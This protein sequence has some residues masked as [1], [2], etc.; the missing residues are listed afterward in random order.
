MTSAAEREYAA[1]AVARVREVLDGELAV[2][3][4]E[5]IARISERYFLGER[6]NVDPHHVTTA[7]RVLASSG[8]IVYR[9]ETTKG[10]GDVTTIEVADRSRRSTAVDRAA[11]R[12]RA[13]YARYHGWANSSVR[14]PRGRIGP[15]GE[16]AVRAGVMASGKLLPASGPDAGEVRSVLGIA[17]RGPADSGGLMIPVDNQG[18]PGVPV[19]VVIEVK[20][21]R[22]WVYPQSEELFQLLDKA[23]TVQE[24]RPD[25]PIVPVLVCRRAHETLYPMAKQFG[26]FVIDA[27]RQWAGAVTD[28]ELLPVRNELDFTDLHAGEEASA[29]V[30]DRFRETLP[31]HCTRFADE[32]ARTCAQSELAGIVHQLRDVTGA[33]ERRALMALFRATAEGLG[34]DGGW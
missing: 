33:P 31:V 7:L 5:L 10:G 17:L 4:P 9:T 2:V 6:G 20:N 25:Q 28:D 14:H 19:T 11:A 16:A 21:I 8:E 1:Q 34:Y 13:L 23:A 12:K 22:S 26:F 32:W 15:A 30:R 24:Q 29:R 3:Q 18:I 27:G